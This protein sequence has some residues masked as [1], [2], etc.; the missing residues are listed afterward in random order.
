[1]TTSCGRELWTIALLLVIEHA[2]FQTSSLVNSFKNSEVSYAAVGIGGCDEQESADTEG[3]P[4]H[5]CCNIRTNARLRLR[6]RA[7]VPRHSMV[8]LSG[9]GA[10]T[11]RAVPDDNKDYLSLVAEYAPIVAAA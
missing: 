5:S 10:A 11:I 9:D 3:L 4:W 2:G 8:F 1:M 6:I 7:R